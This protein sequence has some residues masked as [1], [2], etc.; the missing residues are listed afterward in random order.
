MGYPHDFPAGSKDIV[1]TERILAKGDLDR[2]KAKLAPTTYG[3]GEAMEAL[4]M[5]CILRI[6]I[7]FATEAKKLGW[8]ITRAKEESLSFLQSLAILAPDEM[9]RDKYGLKIGN[10]TSGA[11]S[12]I[13]PEVQRK[14][15][16][17]AEWKELDDI[18]LSPAAAQV[19][20]GSNDD[21]GG[22]ERHGV[23]DSGSPIAAGQYTLERD[24]P[25]AETPDGRPNVG[26]EGDNPIPVRSQTPSL[27]VVTQDKATS[28]VLADVKAAVSSGAV[29]ES[30]SGSN[31]T[32]PAPGPQPLQ[33]PSG[34]KQSSARTRS[35][36]Q[37]GRGVGND[38]KSPE[39]R[40]AAAAVKVKSQ[41]DVDTRS[42]ADY[43]RC[44]VQHVRRLVRQGEL[45]ASKTRPMRITSASLESHMWP[46]TKT[47]ASS[48]RG[49]QK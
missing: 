14:L 41:A 3:P 10:L 40:A 26:M 37:S 17:S 38:A 9:G 39:E 19:R 28:P 25:S 11:F 31:Q 36:D 47:Q 32:Y 15:E 42:A 48:A 46:S 35:A 16:E 8:A 5:K 43:L 27:G 7:A 23:R 20:R 33:P 30:T 45:V 2:E 29:P 18:F 4:V 12:K 22:T 49:P 13:R 44:S 1:E 34:D 6:V 21:G 24:A